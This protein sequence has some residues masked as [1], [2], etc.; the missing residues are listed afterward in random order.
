[1]SK[2]SSIKLK[3]S[4]SNLLL[5]FCLIQLS[6]SY[7]KIRKLS[8]THEGTD[9]LTGIDYDTS[10]NTVSYSVIK[11]YQKQNFRLDF[12]NSQIP[13]SIDYIRVDLKADN[14][15][16]TPLLHFS[17]TDNNC[18]DP[19][20]QIV[21]SP[22][23]DTATLWVKVNEF[24]QDDLFVLVEL[25]TDDES[26]YTL[27]FTGTQQIEMGPNFVYSYLVGSGNKAMDFVAERSNSSEFVTIYAVGS[28]SVSFTVDGVSGITKFNLGAAVTFKSE[29]VNVDKFTIS[30]KANEGDYITVGVSNVLDAKTEENLLE[31]NGLEVSGFLVKDK[32][33][34]QCFEMSSL[35]EKYK[36]KYIYITGRFYNH[37]GEIY[38]RDS[39]FKEMEKTIANTTD[40]F[41]VTIFST[42]GKKNS[43]CVRSPKSSYTSLKV[44]PFT[45]YVT[46]PT[47]IEKKYQ[48]Y[49][50]QLMGQIYRR[51]IPKNSIQFFSSLSPPQNK[52]INF[53]LKVKTGFPKMY[54]TKCNSY[55][56][57]NYDDTS[58]QSFIEPQKLNRMYSYSYPEIS[59]SKPL[60]S[61]KYGIV[62]KCVDDDNA[63]KGYCE[64][65]TS[66]TSTNDELEIVENETFG[67]FSLKND[68]GVFV[69]NVEGE[70]TIKTINIDVM[71]LTGDINFNIKE[72]L[73]Y[74]K[75]YLSN[76]IYYKIST[77]DNN[78]IKT[79]TFEYTAS[80]NS[81]YTF[82]WNANRRGDGETQFRDYISSG[83][84][85]LVDMDPTSVEKYKTIKL[86]NLRY[87]DNKPFLANFFA[88][89]CDFKVTR[90]G[91]EIKFYDGYAQEI[92]TTSSTKYNQDYYDY[93]LNIT[94]AD[95]SN[96]NNKMC[97]LYI[98]GSETSTSTIPS[99]I[100]IGENVNQQIIFEDG[101][102]SVR[103]LYPHPDISKDLALKVNIIDTS[104]YRV[105]V[106]AGKT[107]IKYYE[108]ARTK[109]YYLSSSDFQK[110]CSEN[111]LCPIIIEVQLLKNLLDTNPMAEITIRSVLNIPTYLQK[112]QAKQDF[113][114]GEKYYY[115]YTDIGKNEEGEV[116]VNFLR[117]SGKVYAKVA[118]KDQTSKDE[119]ANWRDVYR[120][121]SSEWEDSLKYDPYLK[122]LIVANEDTADCIEGC[123]LLISIQL[124]SNE[125]YVKDS[126]FYPF[127][128][129]VKVSPTNSAYTDIPKVVI[130][131]DELLIGSVDVSENERI[132][133]FYEIWLPHDSARIEFDWQT[134]L[135][136]LYI[137]LGG[138]RP[139]TRNADFKLLPNGRDQ[140]LLLSKSEIL[141]KAKEK[142]IN[143][144]YAGQIQ[145]LNLVIGIWT[146]KSDSL[147]TEP[148]SLRIHQP[149]ES[150]IDI[151]EV[152][153][154][155][156]VQCR[157]FGVDAR[158][159]RCLFMVIVEDSESS[160]SLI[161]FGAS[162]DR[163][164]TN[165]MY[166]RFILK[167]IYNTH[168]TKALE[169]YIPTS[170]NAEFNS[171]TNGVEYIYIP[172]EKV[173][174]LKYLYVSVISTSTDDIIFLSNF[175]SYNGVLNAN[176]TTEQLFSIP[177][178]RA[179]SLQFNN[180]EDIVANL[181]C[182]SGNAELYWYY[183]DSTKYQLNGYGDRLTI[184]SGQK[185]SSSKLVITSKNTNSTA[186]LDAG[187]VFYVFYY[188][189]NPEINFDEAFTGK[190]MQIAYS[191]T[192][193]PVFLYSKMYTISY[194]INVI[195]NFNNLENT[196]DGK[197]VY[198]NSPFK[199]NAA[200][201]KEN[202]AYLAKNNPELR[203]S[204]EKSIV[205]VYDPALRTAQVFLSVSDIEKFNL[206]ST[207]NPILYFGFEKTDYNE[208]IYNKFNL[209]AQITMANDDVSPLEGVYN[210]GKVGSDTK[211][212]YYK[213][214]TNKSNKVMRVQISFISDSLDYIIGQD[215]E[216]TSNITFT[217]TE[218]INGKRIVTLDVP[219]NNEYLYLIIYIKDDSLGKDQRLNNYCFKYLNANS[220][221]DFKEYKIIG[222]DNNV[223]FSE[224][225]NSNVT[226]INAKFKGIENG[227]NFDITYYLKVV[228]NETHAYRESYDTIAV[229]E[230]P[231]SFVS[232]K[233]PKPNDNIELEIDNVNAQWVYL[234]VI[235]AIRDGEN[236]E[237][238]CYKGKYTLRP[239]VPDGGSSGSGGVNTVVFLVVGGILLL[240][241]IG[242]IVAVI[243]FKTQ[244]TALLNQVKHVSF[245]KT[246]T[247]PDLLLNKQQNTPVNEA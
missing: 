25:V 17:S 2:Y 135:A 147:K 223:V 115:L 218:R 133:E 184:T 239:Y 230:S 4:F 191:D 202:L 71:V 170:E 139:T 174:T 138:T 117:G 24:E 49:P 125:A 168:D 181:V 206:K 193:L 130:Q 8:T 144:P 32:L 118:R 198:I 87:K 233:N 137:N 22:N 113:V 242:L 21:K 235:A 108:L 217:K 152:N 141:V 204:F 154:N 105:N 192:D 89:N 114:C 75:Y 77:D 65:E 88:L 183:D 83:L 128:I 51:I 74:H 6:F 27:T 222:G 112:S 203:P 86:M 127:S 10:T 7:S 64:F 120:M 237:Y 3:S 16:P 110:P 209:E 94:Q 98:S 175:N 164:A 1:M 106:Y 91:K 67:Q 31:P 39:S 177:L 182:I 214:K 5:L 173:D 56:Q 62:V 12:P 37:V 167:D 13:R 143:L 63:G 29:E 54:I 169:S 111:S 148:Y 200:L 205:G 132:Y 70:T 97:M 207:D 153:S 48:F 103:F 119:E 151:T 140:I 122:K 38:L 102:E 199:I 23:S 171:K 68:K 19:R 47:S 55:P 96:Y 201:V 224:T 220:A 129:L 42:S 238:E 210:Y 124:E 69:I 157:P 134:E 126:N 234:E 231:S 66:F 186:M 179:Y 101:F 11:A 208:I 236:V 92:V 81:Y 215:E 131:A 20:Q 33:E 59:D 14:N 79:I 78:E 225:T 216:S 162:S 165:Y 213:L 212:V 121:P 142:N 85:Y 76:K 155:Q 93:V 36:S 176:P 46:E 9:Q 104:V 211:R 82:K 243:V 163:S 185:H 197:L 158:Q 196:E 221:S 178:S 26:E 40:G 145:D 195:V 161:A 189:R 57:C 146:D 52:R 240:L 149:I 15:I 116:L 72:D 28:K 44:L 84:S 187:F 73:N 100:V 232:I 172:S 109:I 156:K 188:L 180:E 35:E 50:P 30:V 159:F 241:V 166:A 246:N 58:L 53:N 136:G 245:Q 95:L 61:E 226:K 247:N 229:S 228:P 34:D 90:E 80:L 41:Y 227:D 190:S 123:Y 107:Q 43:L 60:S 194:D 219:T 99:E 244:N 18:A 150:E 160:Q 45:L